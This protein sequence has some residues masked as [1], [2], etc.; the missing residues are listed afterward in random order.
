[1]PSAMEA[2]STTHTQARALFCYSGNQ[3]LAVAFQS[4]FHSLKFPVMRF[5]SASIYKHG[6]PLLTRRSL[7]NSHKQLMNHPIYIVGW[8]S[9][10][11]RCFSLPENLEKRHGCCCN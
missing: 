8:L 2:W 1:M 11:L 4:T 5:H 3:L 10:W 9:N 6:W 7:Y